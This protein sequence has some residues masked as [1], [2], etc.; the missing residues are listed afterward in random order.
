MLLQARVYNFSLADMAPTT[1]IHVRFYGQEYENAQ[2]IGDSFLIGETSIG[3][4][5]GFNSARTQG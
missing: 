5:P 1:T 4:I 2:L 3:A